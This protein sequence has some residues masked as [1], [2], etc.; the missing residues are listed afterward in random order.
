M[1]TGPGASLL[2]LVRRELT[3]S[4]S[5]R[6]HML[7]CV[8]NAGVRYERCMRLALV[9]GASRGAVGLHAAL[10]GAALQL[11]AIGMKQQY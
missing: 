4:D 3:G 1:G 11:P 5:G 9:R 10:T 8:R 7:M 2:G 6:T